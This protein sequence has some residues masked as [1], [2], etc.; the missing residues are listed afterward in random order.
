MNL[1]YQSSAQKIVQARM[2]AQG[3]TIGVMIAAGVATHA[4][5]TKAIE[6]GP[7]HHNTDHSWRDIIDHEQAAT[8]AA[9]PKRLSRSA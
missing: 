2:W 4:Q 6:E 9:M 5:R 8:E 1:R 7:M 3:L